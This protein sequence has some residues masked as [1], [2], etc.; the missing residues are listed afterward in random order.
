MSERKFVVINGIRIEGAE[1]FMPPE[2]FRQWSDEFA[3]K[4]RPIINDQME[5]RRLSGLEARR[6][7]IPACRPDLSDSED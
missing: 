3:E 4:M 1:E 5:R 2:K 6:H 7:F